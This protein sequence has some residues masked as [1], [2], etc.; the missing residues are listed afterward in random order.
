MPETITTFTDEDEAKE[1]AREQF[2][3]GYGVKLVIFSDKVEAI[4]TP[5]NLRKLRYPSDYDD[6]K[7]AREL[8]PRWWE[9]E[10]TTLSVGRILNGQGCFKDTD[11]AFDYL[12]K[13]WKWQADITKFIEEFEDNEISEEYIR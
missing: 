12:E 4:L 5:P 13:P 1:Y 9:N 8:L 7:Y 11:Q 6:Y 10:D 3:A 2:R